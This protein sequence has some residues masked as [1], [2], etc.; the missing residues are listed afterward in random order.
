MSIRG[1]HFEKFQQITCS[2]L[3]VGCRGVG[4]RAGS[5][6]VLMLFVVVPRQTI[7]HL[8]MLIV[9]LLIVNCPVTDA[10]LCVVLLCW[11][12]KYPD[13]QTICHLG[14]VEMIVNCPV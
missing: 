1:S 8:R 9:T 3:V 14:I 5:Q 12:L 6:L 2:F 11:Q 7:R 10:P 13:F 4:G